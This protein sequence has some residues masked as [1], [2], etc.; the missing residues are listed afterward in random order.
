MGTGIHN[1]GSARAFRA[2]R[3]IFGQ[4]TRNFALFAPPWD[5]AFHRP[6]QLAGLQKNAGHNREVTI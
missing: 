1:R 3:A 6:H 5:P 2:W 4:K